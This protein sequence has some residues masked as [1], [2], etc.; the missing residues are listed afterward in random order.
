M[1]WVVVLLMAL[2]LVSLVGYRS[3]ARYVG[4]PRI[5][6]ERDESGL[7]AL[8][9]SPGQSSY[10]PYFSRVNFFNP[11]MLASDTNSLSGK[12]RPK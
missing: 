10:D 2:G 1:L 5:R 9:G 6:L 4:T 8:K 11:S 7:M 12:N 3:W